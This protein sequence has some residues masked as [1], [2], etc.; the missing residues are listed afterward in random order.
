MCN[1]AL[2][3][4]PSIANFRQLSR[5]KALLTLQNVSKMVLNQL[6]G[7]SPHTTFYSISPVRTAGIF[8]TGAF[9]AHPQFYTTDR[10]A[11]QWL[12]APNAALISGSEGPYLSD[13]VI[14]LTINSAS[15]NSTMATMVYEVSLVMDDTGLSMAS[16]GPGDTAMGRGM[17]RSAEWLMGKRPSQAAADRVEAATAAQQ[18][19]YGSEQVDPVLRRVDVALHIGPWEV[20]D[21][22]Q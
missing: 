14:I 2:R 9:I 6:L 1:A 15:Y 20:E 10:N 12:G 16:A 19:S 3:L 11:S 13:E 18:Q 17:S 5:T 4:A 21:M 8:A 7:I 22:P